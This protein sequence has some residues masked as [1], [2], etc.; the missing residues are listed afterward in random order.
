M[1]PKSRKEKLWSSDWRSPPG[2]R[3]R[4]GRREEEETRS[5]RS[6]R[7]RLEASLAHMSLD[8]EPL[9][10]SPNGT[11]WHVPVGGLAAAPCPGC[12]GRGPHGGVRCREAGAPAG[13]S[14]DQTNRESREAAA[15]AFSVAK[16]ELAGVPQCSLSCER[17]KRTRAGED[18]C[19]DRTCRGAK[20][21]EIENQQKRYVQDLCT[22]T[23]LSAH[24]ICG[25][26]SPTEMQDLQN[27]NP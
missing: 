12:D 14:Q 11:G 23:P 13:G 8:R 6:P 22:Q 10:R 18:F 3:G 16:K 20:F 25:A 17:C 19:G 26:L 9:E 21:L 7:R 5:S 2:G 27:A 4:K 15:N 1:A 24:I